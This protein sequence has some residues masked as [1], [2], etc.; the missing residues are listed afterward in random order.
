M[1]YPE[2]PTGMGLLLENEKI[3]LDGKLESH[4]PTA[5]TV[6]QGHIASCPHAPALNTAGFLSHLSADMAWHQRF[7]AIFEYCTYT[8]IAIMVPAAKMSGETAKTWI[9]CL[10]APVTGDLFQ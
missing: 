1:I 4:V 5:L 7:F 8:F 3:S 6:K 10:D 2:A 9:S